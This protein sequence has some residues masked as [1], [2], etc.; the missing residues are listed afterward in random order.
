MLTLLY[1]T[2]HYV[3]GAS[4]QQCPHDFPYSFDYGKRCCHYDKELGETSLSS[5]SKSCYRNAE[6]RCTQD[7]C[8]DNG[9]YFASL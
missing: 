2:Q 1:L 6:M 3:I 7:R 4:P 9:K 8:V 5:R